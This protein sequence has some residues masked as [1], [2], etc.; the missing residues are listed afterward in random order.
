MIDHL[1]LIVGLVP[2]RLPGDL[3]GAEPLAEVAVLATGARQHAHEAAAAAGDVVHVLY[4]GQL[5]VGHVEEVRRPANWQSKSQLSTWVRSSVTLP[6]A[7]RKAT[8]TPP[9]RVTVRI[10]S[11]CLRS[12]RWSLLWPQVMATVGLP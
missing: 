9:S 1:P 4:R 2:E 5:A 8:G 12:G 7:T 6:L 10:Y 11:S 3:A